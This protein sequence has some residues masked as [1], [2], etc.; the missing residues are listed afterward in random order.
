L[1]PEVLSRPPFTLALA[2]SRP[3]IGIREALCLRPL[4]RRFFNEYPPTFIPSPRPTEA[5]DDG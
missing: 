5:D 2:T 4:Q 3:D 1:K